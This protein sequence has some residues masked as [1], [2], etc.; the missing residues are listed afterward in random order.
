MAALPPTPPAPATP[1]PAPAPTPASLQAQVPATNPNLQAEAQSL[2]G[3]RTAAPPLAPGEIPHPGA[4]MAPQA[5]AP[6]AVAGAQQA[7][8]EISPFKS[9]GEYTP[10]AE[11][12]AMMQK[13][14]ISRSIYK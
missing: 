3:Q 12:V 7:H 10:S 9:T 14:L 4:E 2:L 1:A 13:W 8:A 5:P 6:T 11:A